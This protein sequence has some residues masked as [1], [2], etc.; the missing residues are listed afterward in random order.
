MEAATAR[1]DLD[2]RAVAYGR[3][4]Q[5]V[6]DKHGLSRRAFAKLVSPE[7]PE[8]VRRAVH[9]HLAGVHMPSR[10]TRRHYEAVLGLDSGSLEADDDEEADPVLR[11]AFCLF[12]D[13]MDRLETRR[14]AVHA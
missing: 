13:L 6:L 1:R 12:V 9:R 3:K 10:L 14:Q 5:G 7:N 11:E 2:P 4:L 8:G